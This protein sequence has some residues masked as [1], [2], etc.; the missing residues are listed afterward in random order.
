MPAWFRKFPLTSVFRH[1]ARQEHSCR[2]CTYNAAR[3]R[4]ICR[5]C[6]CHAARQQHSCR[7]RTCHVG[8]GPAVQKHAL[9]PVPPG[10][11]AADTHP[12]EGDPP[13]LPATCHAVQ[14]LQASRW[15]WCAGWTGAA[16]TADDGCADLLA[17]AAAHRL[18]HP[19]GRSCMVSS[20]LESSINERQLLNSSSL[21]RL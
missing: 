20:P 11:Q 2:H 14:K 6:T 19:A 8:P 17:P 13:R 10:A 4:H 9:A 7:R 5:Q 21:N 12:A 16:L 18:C 15:I 3:Q 1:T